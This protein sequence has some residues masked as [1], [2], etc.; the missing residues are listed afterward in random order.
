MRRAVALVLLAFLTGCAAP[1]IYS[2]GHYEAVVY[3]TYAKPGAVPPERQIE[4]L[5]EDY[6]KARSENK[7]VPPGFHAHLGYLYYQIGRL[8]EARRELETEKAR[9][10]ESAVFVD[11]LLARLAR[12]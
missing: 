8:D 10:P 12:K 3:A 7:P 9:F 11:R 5:E 1:T 2:W 6:Q 4:L